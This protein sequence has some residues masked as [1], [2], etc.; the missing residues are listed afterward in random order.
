MKKTLIASAL[1]LAFT[2][3]V[4]AGTTGR[5]TYFEGTEGSVSASDNTGS[6]DRVLGGHRTATS[7]ALAQELN[8]NVSVKGGNWNMAVGG[9]YFSDVAGPATV[10]AKSTQLT[11]ED[12]TVR[13]VIGGSG[14]SSAKN[15]TFSGADSTSLTI[16]SG[17]FGKALDGVNNTPELLVVGGDLIKFDTNGTGNNPV[18]SSTITATNVSIEGGTFDSAII[19]G[20]AA[21]QYYT[22]SSTADYNT[23]VGT[24][25]TTITGGTFND[26]IVAGGL[27]YGDSTSSTVT[28][29]NLTISGASGNLTVNENIY[30]GGMVGDWPGQL[31][32]DTDNPTIKSTV[33]EA[34][35]SIDNATVKNIYGANANY[36]HA[37]LSNDN[38]WI[39]KVHTTDA[40]VVKTNLK[41]TNTTADT[42]QIKNGT[43]ELRAEGNNG[44]TKI[45]TLETAQGVT[46]KLTADGAANDASGGDITKLIKVTNGLGTNYVVSMDEGFYN[47]AVTG[48]A[49]A[50]TQN[51]S[52]IVV[53]TFTQVLVTSLKLNT[54][55]I[56]DIRKR[57]GDLRYT[58]SKNGA[59]VRYDG[60]R[61]SASGISNKFNTLQM[62]Y[63]TVAFRDDVRLGAAVSYTRSDAEIRRGSADLDSYSLALYGT[64]MDDNGMFADV[65][66]RVTTAKNDLTVDGD[67]T[68]D[69]SNMA[70]SL[71]GEFGQRFD[72]AKNFFVEPQVE[73]TYTY[74]DSDTLR[75]NNGA[76]YAFS[77]S[78]SVIGRIGFAAGWTC[79]NQKGQVYVRASALHE[80]MGDA[81]V[82]TGNGRTYEE[83]GQDTWAEIG[84]GAHYNISKN[85]Y[86][87]AD[88]ERT[89][90]AKL[91][92]DFRGTV[93]VRINF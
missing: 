85:A 31:P 23:S 14:I 7:E 73:V 84:L 9:H 5:Y 26:A 79:P 13:Q 55:G 19:G 1:M 64:W 4:C 88:V 27:A 21:I 15:L 18:V 38:Y 30:A 37:A 69:I 90:G 6:V 20:S 66:G 32:V 12:A 52:S 34:N 8:S 41:L 43:V 59:W 80:F 17:T 91:N 10:N 48:E 29:A 16:K 67:K 44:L 24:A 92:E 63:D 39:Y 57:L 54:L 70:Y 72:V 87:W 62:G 83:D 25:N 51:V 58:D 3:S 60:G 53:D 49:G 75:L 36:T 35:V 74:V 76:T 93:G 78:D 47:G 68:G 71:S 28:T 42:V 50:V 11:I 46:V 65:I 77:S 82:T 33:G 81:D 40:A 45:N 89:Q 2:T 61:L 56:N 86:V 22:G